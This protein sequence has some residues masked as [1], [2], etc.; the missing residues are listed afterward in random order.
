MTRDRLL[1]KPFE[2]RSMNSKMSLW[3]GRI[4]DD[5]DD[6]DDDDNDD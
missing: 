4:G 1:R 5:D 6:D 3:V 2:A